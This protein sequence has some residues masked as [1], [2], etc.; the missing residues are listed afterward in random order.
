VIPLSKTQIVS[1]LPTLNGWSYSDGH[2][3]K[4]ITTIDFKAAFALMTRIAFEAEQLN[5]HP[6][7]EN[8][9][10]SIQFKLSTHECAGVSEKDFALAKII[11]TIT[12]NAL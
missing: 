3:C 2:L 6:T 4:T 5:H 1:K 8:S 10:N 7:W 9:Y 11:D 12:K